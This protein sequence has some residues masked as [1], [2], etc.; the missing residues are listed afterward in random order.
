MRF[1][2]CLR[3]RIA[4]SSFKDDPSLLADEEVVE[5]LM[6]VVD[7]EAGDL[8]FPLGDGEVDGFV[9]EDDLRLLTLHSMYGPVSPGSRTS[10]SGRKPQS[11]AQLAR[12]FPLLEKLTSRTGAV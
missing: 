7:E 1:F 3:L 5:E 4:R 6:E 11:S 8:L 2:L 12:N 10:S 9:D